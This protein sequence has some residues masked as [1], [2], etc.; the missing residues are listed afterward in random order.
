MVIFPSEQGFVNVCRLV[1]CMVSC[2]AC[3]D[4]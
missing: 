1:I 4:D 3:S 2:M